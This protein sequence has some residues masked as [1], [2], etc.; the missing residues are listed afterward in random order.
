ML[1][2]SDIHHALDALRRVASQGEP[3]LILGDLVNLTDYR[4]GV[5]A[6]SDVLGAEF[7][8]EAGA[9]RAT[10]DFASMRRV[11]EAASEGRRD[12]LRRAIAGVVDSQYEGVARALATASGFAIHG[13]VDRP[14]SLR[15]ALPGSIEYVHGETRLLDGVL[16]GFIG[17]GVRTPLNTEGEVTEE[18]ISEMLAGFGRVDVLCTHVP[19]AID[20]L[21]T[22]VI[23]GHKERASESILRYLEE[24][25]PTLHLFGD[26]HQPQ[27]S[28]W[29]IGETL[30]HNVGFFRAT[31]R[32]TRVV[33]AD[34]KAVLT[35]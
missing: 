4:T 27:A 19:A 1:A 18:Q 13:N 5:G 20:A 21:R 7:A 34:S 14:E 33:V 25:Q 30:C 2:I 32:A 29:R 17:G 35:S 11:W 24:Y 3:L 10:G 8:R 6:I 15:R 22:D 23:T 28:R 12:E 16:F 31:G 9:A 26:V